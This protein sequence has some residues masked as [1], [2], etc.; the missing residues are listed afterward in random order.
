M[1]KSPPQPEATT[2][3]WVKALAIV[4]AALVLIGIGHFLTGSGPGFHTVPSGQQH[5]AQP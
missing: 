1:A 3:R 4:T 5:G 2:P